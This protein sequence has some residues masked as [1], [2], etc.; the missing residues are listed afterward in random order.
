MVG[1]IAVSICPKD[2]NSIL[3]S[4]IDSP[5]TGYYENETWREFQFLTGAWEG[6]V[7]GFSGNAGQI[8]VE[9]SGP[10]LRRYRISY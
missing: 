7:F 3:V 9:E 6:V 5:W 8:V 10:G 1:E 4:E 2:T